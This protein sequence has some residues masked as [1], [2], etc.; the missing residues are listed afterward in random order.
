M[1]LR[2]PLA[3]QEGRSADVQALARTDSNIVIWWGSPVECASAVQR[4]L[5]DG[6]LDQP[7]ALQ[8][9][10]D[11]SR[12]FRS[13]NEVVPTDQVRSLAM[14]LLARRSLILR[15]LFGKILRSRFPGVPAGLDARLDAVASVQGLDRLADEALVCRSVS[16]FEEALSR[17]VPP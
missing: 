7:T 12:I 8:V 3:V 11:L 5:R 14:Q 6:S 10:A 9:A 13:C 17:E 16:D 2:F 1:P 15:R 4:R